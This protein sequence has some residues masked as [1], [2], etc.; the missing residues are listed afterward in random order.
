MPEDEIDI[1][2]AVKSGDIEAV[3]NTLKTVEMSMQ[4][5]KTRELR[6]QL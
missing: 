6:T 2:K 3:K 1:F 5:L 4:R